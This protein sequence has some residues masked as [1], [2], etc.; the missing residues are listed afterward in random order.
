MSWH[1][2]EKIDRTLLNIAE[3]LEFAEGWDLFV[4]RPENPDERSRG[5]RELAKV[6]KDVLSEQKKK[7]RAVILPTSWD[8]SPAA[9]PDAARR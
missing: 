4:T 3:S 9:G 2:Y 6:S 7:W 8:L 1:S 5:Q